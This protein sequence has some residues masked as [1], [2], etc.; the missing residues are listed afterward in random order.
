[1]TSKLPK[2]QSRGDYVEEVYNSL[3]NAICEGTLWGNRL[4]GETARGH[5]VHLRRVVGAMLQ[6][7]VQRESIWEEHAAI[8]R[9]TEQGDVALAI[10]L[11]ELHAKTAHQHLIGELE[12]LLQTKTMADFKAMAEEV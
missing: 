12:V 11:S 3:V 5:W 2:I 1:M 7:S 6:V 8:A 10:S 4:I 9:A